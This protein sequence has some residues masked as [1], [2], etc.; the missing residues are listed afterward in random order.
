M[1]PGSDP[2][3]LFSPPTRAWFASR[4]GQPT[5]I[6]RIA[7]PIIA[8]GEHVLVTAPT[9]SG[10]TLAAF[11][12]ALDRL[13]GEA[14]PGGQVRVLYVSPLRALGNDIRR[15]LLEPLAELR[16]ALVRRGPA[17]HRPSASCRAPATPR[18]PSAGPLPRAH[19]RS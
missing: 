12:W 2:L 13:L 5:E 10:K 19:P 9:G 3:D 4:I 16:P 18:R 1:A 7:W 6:Q 14:W 8:A 15:N 17:F 11:L